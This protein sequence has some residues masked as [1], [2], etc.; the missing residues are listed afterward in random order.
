MNAMTQPDEI[1]RD[2]R[3]ARLLVVVATVA[4]FLALSMPWYVPD[5]DEPVPASGWSLLAELAGDSTGIYVFVGWY[6]WVVLLAAVAAGVGVLQLRQRWV[7]VALS[8]GLA[9]L[10]ACLLLVEFRFEK[11]LDAVHLAGSWAVL[12]VLV[13]AAVAWGNLAA[14]L[15]ELSYGTA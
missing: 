10:A 11:D 9:L 15:R 3:F 7:C 12:P 1:H 2:A 4:V 14:P 8:T 5:V 13:F 6:G